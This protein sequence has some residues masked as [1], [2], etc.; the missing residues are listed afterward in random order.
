MSLRPVAP[1]SAAPLAFAWAAKVARTPKARLAVGYRLTGARVAGHSD[2]STRLARGMH[3]V[4]VAR[5]APA[6]I[7]ES[8]AESRTVRLVFLRRL[9]AGLAVDRFV[10]G[11]IVGSALDILG[12]ETEID[13]LA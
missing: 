11:G 12:R 13:L 5:R 1:L 2:A 3:T 6:E 7:A 8:I 9:G 4:A 10:A